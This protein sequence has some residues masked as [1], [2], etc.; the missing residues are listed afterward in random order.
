VRQA[1]AQTGG[2]ATVAKLGVTSNAISVDSATL[3]VKESANAPADGN[4]AAALAALPGD[5]WLGFGVS[6]IGDRL[7]SMLQQFTQLG[8][9]AGQDVGGQLKAA[10]QQLGIDLEQDLF[11][12]MGDGGLFVRGTSIAQIGGALVVQTSDPQATKAAIRK[13]ARLVPQ[14]SPSTQVARATGIQG[15][16]DGVAITAEGSPFPILLVQGG[17]KFVFGVSKQAVE[18]ALSRS[19]KLSDSPS[20]KSAASAHSGVDPTFFFDVAP[21]LALADGLGAGN[22][23]DFAQARSYLQQ[24]GSI[25][26]GSKREG[27]TQRAKLVVTLK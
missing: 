15:A 19:T 25:A 11:R 26:A 13:I 4:A 10:Q 23:P 7:R 17:D 27:D 6:S 2:R 9:V 14:L 5:S 21:V 24:F 22:D 8:S 12:W 16:E 1:I 3:G 18:A 20:F